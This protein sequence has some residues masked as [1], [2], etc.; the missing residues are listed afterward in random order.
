VEG[1]ALVAGVV[2]EL[3]VEL[4]VQLGRLAPVAVAAVR[5]RRAFVEPRTIPQ[6]RP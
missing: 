6:P 5:A 1:A 3:V 4:A 2:A